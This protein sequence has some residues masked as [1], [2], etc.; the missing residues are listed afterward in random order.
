VP[1]LPFFV[2]S[3]PA[4]K[5]LD[6]LSPPQQF[7]FLEAR[8][9]RG[10]FREKLLYGTALQQLDRPRSAEREF[11]AAAALAP[12][13]AEAQVAAAVGLFDKDRPAVAFGKLGPLTRVFPKAVTVRFHLGLMLLWIRNVEAAKVQLRKVVDA[14]PSPYERYAQ[15]F[16]QKLG[17]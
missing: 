6:R 17:K 16:L 1:G 2:P 5:E 12:R 14:G 3:F 4:P 8:A 9:R 13:D 15:Q 11:A 10:G 7:A